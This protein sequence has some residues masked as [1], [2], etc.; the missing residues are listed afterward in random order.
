M[1]GGHFDLVVTT[2]DYGPD[3]GTVGNNL[4]LRGV[5]VTSG[6]TSLRS[7]YEYDINGNRI[8]E[9][10]PQANLSACY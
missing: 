8:S 7:C 4:W 9:T 2:Y 3:T 10:A 5:V 6:G 1:L